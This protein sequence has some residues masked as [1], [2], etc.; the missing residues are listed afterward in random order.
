MIETRIVRLL[1]LL[2]DDFLPPSISQIDFDVESKHDKNIEI[3]D[4]LCRGYSQYFNFVVDYNNTM[5]KGYDILL[6]LE[7]VFHGDTEYYLDLTKI[8]KSGNGYFNFTFDSIKIAEEK[9]ELCIP[10]KSLVCGR[11]MFKFNIIF[12]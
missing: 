10:I 4:S 5:I 1:K 12:I 7:S 3:L 8:T 9:T 11:E 2:D 6:L